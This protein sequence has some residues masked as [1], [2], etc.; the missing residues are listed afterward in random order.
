M[1]RTCECGCGEPTLIAKVTSKRNGHIKGQPVRFVY[2]HHLRRGDLAPRFW[3]K[4]NKNG[5]RPGK[6]QVR[7]HPELKGTK[8]WPYTAAL[9][10]YGYGMFSYEGQNIHAH[11]VAYFL[12]Y[13]EW[14]EPS[15]LHK[16]DFA[17]CCNPIHI[18][19]GTQDENNK[20]TSRKG[21]HKNQW[22]RNVE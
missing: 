19:P 6:E 12:E 4:V 13:G 21:R 14:P 10:N 18:R 8:C 15:G 20:D 16:C 22:D 11:R 17:A 3:A 7:L 2:T 1:N 5:P 9:D